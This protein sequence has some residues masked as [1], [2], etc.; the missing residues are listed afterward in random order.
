MADDDVNGGGLT[1]RVGF[2]NGRRDPFKLEGKA[3]VAAVVTPGLVWLLCRWRRRLGLV[4]EP[5]I[6]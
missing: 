4:E 6:T 5:R 1:R 3:I 2:S